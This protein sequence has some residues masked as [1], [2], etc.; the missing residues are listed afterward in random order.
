[1]GLQGASAQPRSI[2]KLPDDATLRAD[3]LS[4]LSLRAAAARYGVSSSVVGK[5]WK[6][7]GLGGRAEDLIPDM[8]EAA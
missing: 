8:K 5:H 6:R 3:R 2:R 1:M 7:F 4:G